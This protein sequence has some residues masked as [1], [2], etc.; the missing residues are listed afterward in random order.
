MVLKPRRSAAFFLTTTTFRNT[1]WRLKPHDAWRIESLSRGAR[2][3]PLVAQLLLN[4]GI[5]DPA[6]A[7]AFLEAKMGSL[8]DPE[9]LP[10]AARAADRIVGAIRDG[11]KIVVYGDYDVDGVC[12]T[13]VLWACLRLAGATELDYYIPHRVE[14]GY[15][16]NAEALRRLVEETKASLIVTVDCGI[17]AIEEA[18]LARQ[19]GVELII[20]DHHTIGPELPAADEIV[21]P[22]LPGSMYPSGD[23]CG[24]GV[25]FK[26]AWQV[27]KSFGDGK[28]ASPHLRN[29]L[30]GSMGLVALA[31]IADVVPISD[32]NRIIVRHGL[33]AISANPSVGLRALMEVSGSLDKKR[34]TAGMVG[35][36]LAPRINAAGRLERAMMAVQMLTTDDPAQARSI[37]S[38]LD[39]CNSR[40][41]EVERQILNEARA[42]I[43][44]EGGLG[45]RHS[46][47]LAREGWH[48]GV[49][50]IV[51]SRLVDLFH[52]P[53]IV[54]SLGPEVSQGS[55]RSIPGFDVYQAIKESSGHLLAF[56]GHPAAAGLKL[57]QDQLA[58]F[59]RRFEE[60]CRATL[61]AD[62][63]ERELAIDAEVPLGALTLRV[64]EEI[65][66]L[67]PHGLSNPRPLLLATSLEIAGLP[68]EVGAQKQHL[69]LRLKQGPH[70]LKAIG[71]N[72]AAKAQFL[73]PGTRC[74]V[75]FHPSINEWNHRRDV[76]LEIRDIAPED[77]SGESHS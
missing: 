43:D 41:Q 25:A 7:V 46:L 29:F 76:Q 68:R 4:R 15:G 24:A 67:E 54:I 18:K 60:S 21:H 39:S 62:Q 20:T 26:L 45:D 57:R 5:E 23:L 44:A 33:A 47:V 10:G 1:R 38:V 11:R 13:S 6:R 72:L 73:P 42:M 32:E 70:E 28:R 35:F 31:T 53:A 3:S 8:H 22:R 49:I 36:S 63:F 64:V 52:R 16:V 2:I 55:A 40:R 56:G 69:Q 71:W 17:S 48:A 14:E 37:A 30:V 12:G 77:P 51:A 74:S 27:C 58:D 75:V 19:L 50:G 66:R 61:Q 59:T 9:L 65:E 34:L